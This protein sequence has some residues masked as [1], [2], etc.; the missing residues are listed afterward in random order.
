MHMP[1]EVEALSYSVSVLLFL[2][3]C[4]NMMLLYLTN[5]RDANVRSYVYKMISSTLS[6][7]CAVLINRATFSCIFDQ[8]ITGKPPYG[9]GLPRP[10]PLADFAIGLVLLC[11]AFFG[12]NVLLYH[13]QLDRNFMFAVRS[14]GGHITAFAGIFTFGSLQQARFARQSLKWNVTIT[15]SSSLVFLIMRLSSRKLRHHLKTHGLRGQYSRVAVEE[16]MEDS[17]NNLPRFRQIRGFDD[18]AVWVEEA[19]EAED[20]ATALCTSFLIF[21]GICFA[22]I[23][24]L[25]P[26]E[27]DLTEYTTEQRRTLSFWSFVLLVVVVVV[28]FLRAKYGDMLPTDPT[29][30]RRRYPLIAQNFLALTMCW[31]LF[32]VGDWFW[33]SRIHNGSM[34][35]VVNAVVVTVVAVVVIIIMDMFADSLVEQAHTQVHQDMIVRSKTIVEKQ[36]VDIQMGARLSLYHIVDP[37][38]FQELCKKLNVLP[39]KTHTEMALRTLIGATGFLVGICWDRCFETSDENIVESSKIIGQHPVLAK[40]VIAFVLVIVVF[41]AWMTYLVPYAQLT[42]A[43]HWWLLQHEKKGLLGFRKNDRDSTATLSEA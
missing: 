22:N 31:S 35:K 17:V 33:R 18:V 21:Q 39:D 3:L 2:F 24:K 6:I 16:A 29:S 10:P 15:A 30:L 19:C 26:M 8:I 5:Y 11:I 12:I 14:M 43:E 36:E 42:E 4:V 40:V 38:A 41:P 28:T 23:G 25:L 1:S 7:L 20:E 34:A 32:R 27:G 9:L 37:A 13:L